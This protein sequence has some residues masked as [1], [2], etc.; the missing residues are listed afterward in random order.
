MPL[1]C[2]ASS[3]HAV[4]CPGRPCTL[5]RPGVASPG[6][7]SS[8]S[9]N[10]QAPAPSASSR[11]K[12]GHESE[13]IRCLQ[14]YSTIDDE[15][16]PDSSLMIDLIDPCTEYK[17]QIKMEKHMA[18]TL[19]E[20]DTRIPDALRHDEVASFAALF[21]APRDAAAAATC[22]PTDCDEPPAPH[23][24]LRTV[25]DSCSIEDHDEDAH[26]GLAEAGVVGVADGVGGYRDDGVDASAVC[27]LTLLERAHEATVEASTPAASTAVIV[28]LSGG[29][30]RWAYVGDSGFVVFRDGR[31]LRRSRPQ[32]HY[33]NCPYQLS[34]ERDGSADEVADAEV[35][36]VPA[37]EG[38]V[39][40]VA[41][42]G[43]FDN[44]TDDELERIVRM[45]TAL[46]FS[47][48]NMAEVLAGF[49]FEASSVMGR[50]ER[51][52]AFFTG[53]KPDDITV[54]VAYIVSSSF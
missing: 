12:M 19:T 9:L 28:S 46:G 50:R 54:V 8:G 37:K 29:A 36:K 30:L 20:I 45:G 23:G 39:V 48:T 43:L 47:P 27:P 31:I 40:V 35:G 34:S 11:R 22:E 15:P 1:S 52:K 2:S 5:L 44:V 38:D 41:T 13:S 25:F 51:G 7:N 24:G 6:A 4:A 21:L 10:S 3:A 49:A 33:F 16:N 32:Q 14:N 18:R 42:D 17:A 53:G 26:F